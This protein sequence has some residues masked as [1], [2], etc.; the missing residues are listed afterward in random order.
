MPGSEGLFAFA[1]LVRGRA[2]REM[3]G[4]NVRRMV[5]ARAGIIL[6]IDDWCGLLKVVGNFIC[7]ISWKG[8]E[9]LGSIAVRDRSRG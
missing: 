5:G 8:S 3:G 4:S 7:T 6:V 9:A 2:D 1:V